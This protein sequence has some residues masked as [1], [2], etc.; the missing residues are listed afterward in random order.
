MLRRLE[1]FV[2]FSAMMLAIVLE[3]AV[4]YWIFQHRL[5]HSGVHGSFN[6]GGGWAG[7]ALPRAWLFGAL[8]VLAYQASVML[9]PP[10]SWTNGGKRHNRTAFLHGWRAVFLMV[11]QGLVLFVRNANAS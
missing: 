11:T 6:T 1:V 10:A 9:I 8:L 3:G 4:I 5:P 7:V 2:F